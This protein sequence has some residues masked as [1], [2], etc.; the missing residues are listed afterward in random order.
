MCLIDISMPLLLLLQ[1]FGI[2][3]ILNLK[4]KKNLGQPRSLSSIAFQ[5]YKYVCTC[6]G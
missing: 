2:K 6:L 4:W 1:A 5:Q 3:I